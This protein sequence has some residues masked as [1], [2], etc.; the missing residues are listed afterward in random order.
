MNRREIIQKVVTLVPMTV[1]CALADNRVKLNP[2]QRESIDR[3]NKW[4]EEALIQNIFFEFNDKHTRDSVIKLFSSKLQ[5][6]V[7][8]GEITDDYQITCDETNNTP[9]IIG[10]N[11]FVVNVCISPVG[12]GFGKHVVVNY[13]CSYKG[14]IA[15]LDVI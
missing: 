9:Q 4:A 3:L 15:P 14:V 2:A 8:N 11:R 12:F 6:M 10:S 1:L 7:R 13:V 5:E